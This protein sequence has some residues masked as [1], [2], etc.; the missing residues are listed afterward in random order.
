MESYS[1]IIRAHNATRQAL[2]RQQGNRQ[3]SRYK[4]KYYPSSI[5]IHDLPTF[6]ASNQEEVFHVVVSNKRPNFVPQPITPAQNLSS[7]HNHIPTKPE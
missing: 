4:K 2:S 3:G 6:V 5:P 1:S 7:D